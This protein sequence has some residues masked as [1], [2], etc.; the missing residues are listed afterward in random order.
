MNAFESAGMFFRE[1]VKFDWR[2][3]SRGA[4]A[5]KV[6]RSAFPDRYEPAM[7]G[8]ESLVDQYGVF[9]RG[10]HARGKGLMPKD[11]IEPE[12][13]LSPEQTRAF[14]DLVYRQLPRLS[15]ITGPA[16]TAAVNAG[17]G[18]AGAAANAVVPGAGAAVGA[19]AA[20]AA[21]MAGWYVGQVTDGLQTS[22]EDFGRDMAQIPRSMVD[23]VASEF[24]PGGVDRVGSLVP[25]LPPLAAPAPEPVASDTE[26]R[27]GDIHFNGYGEDW[28]WSKFRRLESERLGGKVGARG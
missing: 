12:R 24:M 28:A 27:G 10:G 20:P 22:V 26:S 6:Q 8:A 19:V 5:Q 21:E 15:S 3:M 18:A 23:S 1:L 17:A 25:S 4:A 9:D 7:A 2:S 13:V 14:D 16:A 11:V